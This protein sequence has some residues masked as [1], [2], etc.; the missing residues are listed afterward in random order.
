VPPR[1][2][3]HCRF[4]INSKT[5]TPPPA[6]AERKD[7]ITIGNFRHAPNWDAVLT[8]RNKIWP[9]IRKQIPG[10]KCHV[11]GAYLPPKAKQLENKQLGFQ[12]HGFVEDAE[13]A[14]RS[15][16]ILLAPINFGAGIKGKLV[17]A[18]K[19]STP[20]VTTPIGSEGL[21]THQEK[22]TDSPAWPG[23]I[24]DISENTEEFISSAIALYQD[25]NHWL[26]NS[27]RCEPYF[28]S[29]FDY[30]EQSKHLLEKLYQV[31]ADLSQHRN[32]HFFGQVLQHHTT[33]ST[34]YMSQWIEAKSKLK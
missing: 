6:Y 8:L 34:K 13:N 9:S 29:L 3:H 26:E 16:R 21:T 17:D 31:L 10:V 28:N 18:M 23:A 14:I 32:K 27:Q 4:L 1:L 20:S 15:A 19:C 5:S 22:V 25:E 7:F 30:A 33:S 24:C 12:V 11:Y 2:L